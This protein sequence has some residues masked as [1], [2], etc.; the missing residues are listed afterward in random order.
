MEK[1]ALKG[2]ISWARRY[3]NTATYRNSVEKFEGMNHFGGGGT[4]V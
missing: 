4:T 3:G 1:T 2:D